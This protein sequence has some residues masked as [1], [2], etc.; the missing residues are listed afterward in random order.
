MKKRLLRVGCVSLLIALAFS[1]AAVADPSSAKVTAHLYD[2]TWTNVNVSSF[3]I[4]WSQSNAGA[5]DLVGPGHADG[6]YSSTNGVNTFVSATISDASGLAQTGYQTTHLADVAAESQATGPALTWS[7]GNSNA[8]QRWSFT[9]AHYGPVSF[10]AKLDYSFDLA[11]DSASEWAQGIFDGDIG[12]WKSGLTNQAWASLASTYQVQNGDDFLYSDTAILNVKSPV[13]FMPG[14]TGWFQVDVITDASAQAVVP[15][16][17][18]VLLG[19]LG[20]SAAGLG[21]RRLA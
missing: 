3:G 17:A 11:T 4:P 18:G 7:H 13:P 12:V 14:E 19:F 1:R 2:V 16:P 6:P 5:N 21:L 20:L 10:S 15:V 8:T 9:A